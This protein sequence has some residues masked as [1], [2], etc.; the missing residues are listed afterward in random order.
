MLVGTEVEWPKKTREF[1]SNLMDSTVWNEFDFRD[2]DIVI[3]TYAKSGTTWMQQIIAQLLFAGNTELEVAEMSPWMDF[4][5]PPKEAQLKAVKAQ[6]HRRFVK[7]H[8]P[9][10]AV[11]YSPKAKYIYIGRDGR[12]V[13][14]S[15][16]NH[17]RTLT[18]AFYDAMRNNPNKFGPM[19]DGPVEDVHEFYRT[20]FEK[21]GYPYWPFW[22]NVRTWWEIRNL[23]NILLVHFGVLKVHMPEEMRRIAKFLDITIDESKWDEIVEHCT[24]DWMRANGEKSVP[25]HGKMWEDGVKSFIHKG[26]NG[27]WVDTLTAE[28]SEAYEKRALAELGPEC[29][30]WLKTGELSKAA[31]QR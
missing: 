25:L 19:M 4:R 28:E 27:R 20:W 6:T 12:D 24:F 14:W 21:D 10:D 18:P 31:E 29:A 13:A 11:V 2:D 7:T 17:H 15:L 30:Y 26:T 3:S 23:P 1:H 8:L 9:L 16:H 22:E 5:L